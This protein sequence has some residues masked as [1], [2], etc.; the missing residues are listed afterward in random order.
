MNSCTV[1][2]L[3][4]GAF[5]QYEERISC[6]TKQGALAAVVEASA[7]PRHL[8]G[9]PLSVCRS[10]RTGSSSLDVRSAERQS[11]TPTGTETSPTLTEHG[12]GDA[13]VQGSKGGES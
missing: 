7:S 3:Q 12:G 5:S 13:R 8:L 10:W 4:C 6:K 9:G 1:A 11:L 2:L